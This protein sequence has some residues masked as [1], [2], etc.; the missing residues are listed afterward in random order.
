MITRRSTRRHAWSALAAV[1]GLLLAACS[2][3]T[4]TPGSPSS[5]GSTT[6]SHPPIRH[7]AVI[8]L[9]NKGYQETFG[10][11]SQAPYLASTLTS[12]GQ[13][14]TQYYGIGHF[15]A[16]N[17]IAQVSGQAPDPATQADC[18]V[19][20]D[21]KETG[22]APDGQVVGNGC[23][24]PASVKTIADQL[25]QAHLTWRAYAEDMGNSPTQPKT[26]RHPAI[27]Q[28]DPTVSARVGDQFA[29]RHVPFLYF[30]SIIDS[31]ACQRD[32]VPLSQLPADLSSASS[33]PN[34]LF[35]TPN[36]CHDGH[37]SPCVDGEPGGLVSANSFLQTWVPTILG[38][39]AFRSDGLLVVTFDESDVTSSHDATA[40]CDEQPGPNV[41]QAGI[42]GPGGGLTGTVLIGQGIKPG[43]VNHTPY[44]HYSLLCSIENIFGLPHL[45][46]AGQAGLRCFGSDVFSGK[47]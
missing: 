3:S 2:S 47:S 44:N 11:G 22:T 12:K 10:P 28:M 43:S 35:I 4:S 14:L 37:D 25:E 26:C 21:F 19:Y 39:P 31:P 17:Y 6:P 29:T 27:G 42:T 18:S 34:F 33:T 23:I 40:C 38:S 30:H 46:Y 24:Y 13:L 15:S 36:L 1:G 41:K 8:V 45:G 5:T 32:V 16:D 9:E 7:V 20:S